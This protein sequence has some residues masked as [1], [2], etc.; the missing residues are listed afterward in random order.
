MFSERQNFTQQFLRL[1]YNDSVTNVEFSGKLEDN[2]TLPQMLGK[3]ALQLA[4]LQWRLILV[5]SMSS[6]F[7]ETLLSHSPYSYCHVLMPIILSWQLFSLID[8]C[9][10]RCIY[11]SLYE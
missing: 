1:I 10:V 6:R 2:F 9:L 7:G 5:F 4:W 11:G 3:V 8:A